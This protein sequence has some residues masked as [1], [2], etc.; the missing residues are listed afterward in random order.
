MAFIISAEQIP[1]MNTLGDVL[2][3]VGVPGQVEDPTSLR[4]VFLLNTGATVAAPPRTLG[5]VTKEQFDAV[6]SA[7]GCHTRTNKFR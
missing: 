4:A 3:H 6:V 5:M 2:D 7:C 1:R